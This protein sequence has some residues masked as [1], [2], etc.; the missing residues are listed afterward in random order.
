MPYT[1]GTTGLATVGHVGLEPDSWNDLLD[2]SPDLEGKV[3][4]LGTDRW[5]L[6]CRR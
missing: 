2:P 6:R 4:M 1:W 5:L 3:T